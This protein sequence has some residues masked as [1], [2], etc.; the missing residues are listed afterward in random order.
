[1]TA[2]YKGALLHRLYERF[3][4]A[5]KDRRIADLRIGLSYVGV[6]LDDGSAGLAAVLP[7]S[8]PRGCTVLKDAGTFAGSS[9][10]DML[11]Y[12]VD[13]KNALH[14]AMGVALANALSGSSANPVEDREA[15]TYFDLKPGV[16]VVMVGLFAPLVDRIRKTGAALSIIEKNPERI[17]LLS[18]E[19]RRKALQ[20]SHVAIITATTLLNNTFE[21]TINLLGAPRTVAVIGPSTPL[22]PDIF[23]DTPVTHLGGAVVADAARVLQIISEGGGTPALRP[24]LRFVNMILKT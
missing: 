2:L 3:T 19:D 4:P 16:N 10:S 18:P 8:S 13:G 21:E 7:D 23:S 15:T 6:R 9:A 14:R 12:L 22:V 11:Q 24:H 17:D 5:A 1:M 20:E